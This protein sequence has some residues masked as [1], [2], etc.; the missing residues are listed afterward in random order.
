[1]NRYLKLVLIMVVI[2]TFAERFSANQAPKTGIYAMSPV[3]YGM[4]L[5]TPDGRVVFDYMTKKP[6]MAE[7]PLTSPSVACFHPVLTPS[8]DPISMTL[9]AVPLTALYFLGLAMVKWMP[10]GKNAFGEAYDP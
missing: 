6:P 2:G 7:V 8:G 3:N 4:Q 5:K 10:R 1:M 9:M